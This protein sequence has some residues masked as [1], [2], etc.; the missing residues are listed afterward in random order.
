MLETFKK[1]PF[2]I[3]PGEFWADRKSLWQTI[4]DYIQF[5][6][7]SRSNEIIV[8]VGD[9]GCGTT[10]TLKYLEKFLKQSGAFVSYFVTP[11]E[12]DISSLFRSFLDG[13]P[14]DKKK[15][16]MQRLVT[17]LL[18]TLELDKQPKLRMPYENIEEELGKI[19]INLITGSRLTLTQRRILDEVEILEKI[20]SRT[21]I[22]NRILSE[23]VTEEW[24]VFILLDEFDAA[25]LNSLG[26]QELLL[27][28]RRLYDETMW[29]MCLVIGLKGEPKDVKEKLSNALYSRMSLQ[30]IYMTPLSREEGLDFLKDVL[31][32]AYGGREGGSPFLPFTE[33]SAKLLVDIICP[34]TP[35]RFLKICSLVFEEA[36]REGAIPINSDFVYSLVTKF[37]EIEIEVSVP[38]KVPLH[39]TVPRVSLVEFLK[40]KGNPKNHMDISLIFSYWLFHK[41]NMESYNI[42]DIQKCYDE[43]RISKPKNPTDIMNKLQGK[44]YVKPAGEKDG[45]KAWVITQSGDEYVEKMGA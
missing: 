22:W 23:L 34:C 35:R 17:E 33:E 42:D 2:I 16:I 13:I 21:E 39:K 26:A 43:A 45:K 37:G 32:H 11:I 19:I 41:E 1:N 4:M 28:L 8:L 29:G 12:G 14:S 38:I 18:E 40:S 6:R 25:L 20:P 44:G 7:M 36:R 31:K 15:M 10:H 24:P 30:P 9:Y 5:I 27:E 3:P